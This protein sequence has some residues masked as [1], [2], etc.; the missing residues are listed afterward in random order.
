MERLTGQ[1]IACLL[2]L[3]DVKANPLMRY[4]DFSRTVE[5]AEPAQKLNKIKR[6][7]AHPLAETLN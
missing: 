5:T 1:S 7:E 6:K 3:T 4:E 2:E